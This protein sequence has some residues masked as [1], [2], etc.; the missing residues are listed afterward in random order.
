MKPIAKWLSILVCLSAAAVAFAE[1][2]QEKPLFVEVE[3][4]PTEAGKEHPR[5]WERMA[6][7]KILKD[8]R[9]VKPADT[10]D[11]RELALSLPIVESR[12]DSAY[13]FVYSS[14]K[15][16]PDAETWIMPGDGAQYPVAIRRLKPGEGGALRIEVEMGL[17]LETIE[18]RHI[19]RLERRKGG[20][21]V[22]DG[23]LLKR[24]GEQDDAVQ[25][26]TAVDSKSEGKK[27]VKPK[28]KGRSQ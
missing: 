19:A 1:P 5:Y 7:G 8:L 26:A 13:K 25:P 9:S 10:T 21:F 20:W 4:P 17:W 28:S 15:A 23:K 6:T 12:S 3:P 18:H 14:S 11:L 27:K 22:L 16:A 24:K 2:P